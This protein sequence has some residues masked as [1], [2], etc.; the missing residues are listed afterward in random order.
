MYFHFAV[1]QRRQRNVRKSAMHVQ[2]CFFANQNLLVHCRSR[3]RRRRRCLSSIVYRGCRMLISPM[4]I[5][6]REMRDAG[7]GM[8]ITGWKENLGRNDGIEEL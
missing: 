4:G 6:G 7:C 8:G 1:A 3:C 2:S 5:M